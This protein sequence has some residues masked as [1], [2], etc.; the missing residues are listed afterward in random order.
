M[1]T[2]GYER[3]GREQC[4][5]KVK[6]TA[7][8]LMHIHSAG[9]C[10]AVIKGWWDRHDAVYSLDGNNHDPDHGDVAFDDNVGRVLRCWPSH[11]R[12]SR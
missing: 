10:A 4:A 6:Y 8:E 5:R 1:Q 3:H 2:D 11:F 7:V 9:A 12:E